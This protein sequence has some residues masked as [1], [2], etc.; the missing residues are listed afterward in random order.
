[1]QKSK[2]IAGRLFTERAKRETFT[3]ILSVVGVNKL[4]RAK[5]VVRTELE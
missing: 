5:I 1:M 4:E 3:R 2:L